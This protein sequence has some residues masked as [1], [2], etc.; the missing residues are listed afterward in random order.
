LEDPGD[1][2]GQ[3]CPASCCEPGDLSDPGDLDGPDCPGL[4]SIPAW[5]ELPV[6]RQAPAGL[7]PAGTGALA[8]LPRGPAGRLLHLTV[9]WRTLAGILAE[10]GQLSRLGPVTAH[11][12]RHLA[13]TAADDPETEWKVIVTDRNGQAIA[14][15]R[16][17]RSRARS[18]AG[19]PAAGFV[20]QVI[21]TVPAFLARS[22]PIQRPLASSSAV[23]GEAGAP[24][25]SAA[26]YG[27][28][29]SSESP[30]GKI[31]AAALSAAALAAARAEAETAEAASQGTSGCAH[32]KASLAYRPPP[33]LREYVAA[34]DQTCRSPVCRQPASRADL[35]HTV[36]HD[37]GG[38]TCDCNLGGACR[39]HHRLKQ[40]PGWQLAQPAPGIFLWTTPAGRTYTQTPDTYPA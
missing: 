19:A 11:T 2:D 24:A 8:G 16:I 14:V 26:S 35:D 21:L 18:P 1:P 31:L 3:D 40:R 27:S 25:E 39:T 36:P 23:P 37:Q 4:V 13:G 34:R 33:R 29:P 22:S 30:L 38:R 6:P 7:A 28:G 32:R 15:T 9:P 5:P 20:S 12:A 10:P 17:R